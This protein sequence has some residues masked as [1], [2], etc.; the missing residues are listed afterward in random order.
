MEQ[1]QRQEFDDALDNVRYAEERAREA[2]RE[3]I[4]LVR[5]MEANSSV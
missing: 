1:E 3:R 5:E 4:A 2:R